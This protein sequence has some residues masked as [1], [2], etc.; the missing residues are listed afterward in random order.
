MNKVAVLSQRER[1]ELFGQ[2]A[3]RMGLHPVSVEKDFWV[4]WSLQQLFSMEGLRGQ[5]VFKG[6]TSL[7]KCFGLIHRFSEL[8]WR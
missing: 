4:C 6:G 5:L 7:S 8:I 1:A 3:E 2:T